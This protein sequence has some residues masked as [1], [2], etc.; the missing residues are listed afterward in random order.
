MVQKSV[1]LFTAILLINWIACAASATEPAAAHRIYMMPMLETATAVTGWLAANGFHTLDTAREAQ[2]IRF[3]V[4]RHDLRATIR[5]RM[6]SPLGTRI[7]VAPEHPDNDVWTPLW[8]HL[9]SYIDVPTRKCPD[10]DVTPT[11]V[12]SA[13]SATVCILAEREGKTVQLSGFAIDRQGLI[14]STAHDLRAHQALEVRL[15]DGRSVPG[16]VVAL[17]LHRD[18][19]LIRIPISMENVVAI[20]NGQ[21]LPNPG[22]ALFVLGCPVNGHGAVRRG[23]LDGPPRQVAGAP[24]WQARMVV[25]PG[26]SGSPVLDAEGRLTAVV[27]GRFRGADAIGFLIPLET[28]VQFLE[29]H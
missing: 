28:L 19:T 20:H 25:E 15:A 13:L 4:Q 16:Q 14:V 2:Q 8:R 11:A 17:D 27:K 26:S 7:E 18:L 3:E 1:Q 21:F 5:L 24:L 23:A 6:H 10:A 9:D 12:L 22:G 29:N